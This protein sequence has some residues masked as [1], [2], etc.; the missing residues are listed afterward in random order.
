MRCAALALLW[1]AIA[2]PGAALA[3]DAACTPARLGELARQFR[4]DR[5]E[6]LDRDSPRWHQLHDWSGP[7]HARMTEIAEC[8]TQRALR[9][10]ALEA[11]LGA[12]DAVAAPGAR[13]ATVPVPAGEE[14]LVYWWRGGHD[15]LYFVVRDGAVA[16]SAWWFAGE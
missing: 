6:A 9:R 15:Y 12:P 1:L 11:L 10:D 4:A 7:M 16:A 5:V 8:A 13:H 3:A 14:H 2:G